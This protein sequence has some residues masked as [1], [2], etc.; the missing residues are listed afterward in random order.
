MFL[1]LIYGL[2]KSL[3]LNFIF[4]IFFIV[5]LIKVMLNLFFFKVFI[6]FFVK[7]LIFGSLMLSFVYSESVVVFL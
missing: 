7:Y 3:S 2:L 4:K 5:V 1:V 6:N